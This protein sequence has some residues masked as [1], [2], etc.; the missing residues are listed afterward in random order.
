MNRKI[1]WRCSNE[2]CGSANGKS[3]LLFCTYAELTQIVEVVCKR[4][5][6]VNVFMPS[7]NGD[8]EIVYVYSEIVEQSA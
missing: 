4:C 5:G 6:K 7:T 2:K 1:E 8:G 3:Q